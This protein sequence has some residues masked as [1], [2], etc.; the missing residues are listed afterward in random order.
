MDMLLTRGETSSKMKM[1]SRR[2]RSNNL[3]LAVRDNTTA[4]LIHLHVRYVMI[5]MLPN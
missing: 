4:M 1:S 3:H 2:T 5:N